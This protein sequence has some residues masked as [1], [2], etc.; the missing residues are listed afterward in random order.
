MR[1]RDLPQLLAEVARVL[2][3]LVPAERDRLLLGTRPA[4]ERARSRG[5]RSS[6]R[7]ARARARLRRAVALLDARCPGGP[8]CLRRALLEAS[9]DRGAAREPIYLHLSAAGGP[10]ASHA[11]LASVPADGR[12]YDATFAV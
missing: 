3:I 1:L 11:R 12:R 10:G 8:N 7:D 9:L 4:V 6:L 5:A 2:A